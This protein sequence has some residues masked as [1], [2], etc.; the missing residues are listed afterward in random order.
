[1]RGCILLPGQLWEVWEDVDHGRSDHAQCLAWFVINASDLEPVRGAGGARGAE[2]GS[3]GKPCAPWVSGRSLSSGCRGL[4]GSVPPWQTVTDAG[5]MM[6]QEEAAACA[7]RRERGWL[8]AKGTPHRPSQGTPVC[9]KPTRPGHRIP[10]RRRCLVGL[11]VNFSS[12]SWREKLQELPENHL[13]LR[14]SGAGSR[15]CVGAGTARIGA[16]PLPAHTPGPRQGSLLLAAP[17][18]RPRPHRGLARSRLG[19]AVTSWML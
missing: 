4:V 11:Q 18:A 16:A 12:T 13:L 14:L 1:M 6:G 7:I 15:G 10:E 8:G 17:P 3:L 2:L 19:M 5:G 9:P